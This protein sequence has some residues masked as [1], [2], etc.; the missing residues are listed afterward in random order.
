[1]SRFSRAQFVNISTVTLKVSPRILKCCWI[2]SDSL[3]A[4]FATAS[5][6]SFSNLVISALFKSQSLSK[7]YMLNINSTLS[8]LELSKHF[9]KAR[10][11]SENSIPFDLWTS[12]TWNT[13]SAVAG[14]SFGNTDLNPLTSS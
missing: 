14:L 1:M 9:A 3:L 5:F 7:S 4:N 2:L 13:W 12:K 11:N 10:Q 8:S 6:Y